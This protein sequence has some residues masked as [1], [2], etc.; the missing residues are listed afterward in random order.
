LLASTFVLVLR[1]GGLYV[2]LPT[3]AITEVFRPLPVE[4]VGEAPAFVRGLAVVRGRAIP[5][6]DLRLFL[7]VD[8]PQEA[9][10]WVSVAVAGRAVALAVDEVLEVRSLDASAL[11]QMPP[12]LAGGA[13]SVEALGSLDSQLLLLLQ[14]AHLVPEREW[15]SPSPA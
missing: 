11:A 9:Q 7:G 6:L 4:P 14:A 1:C 8:A 10:R 12:L 2:C 5:V 13:P 3:A 15:L